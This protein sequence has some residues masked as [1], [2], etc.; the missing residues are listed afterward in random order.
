M[1]IAAI[2]A[3]QPRP[4]QIVSNATKAAV[5]NF[6]KSL[7]IRYA[8]DNVRVNCV[9]PGLILTPRRKRLIAKLAQ[10]RGVTQ[11]I[12]LQE[13]A[14]DVPFGRLGLPEEVAAAVLFLLS[15][16]AGF[17]TGTSIDVDGGEARYI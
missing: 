16:Q 12:I 3:R 15:D 8:K 13:Q 1:N 14:A 5:L 17:I 6:S 2:S 10:D 4:R 9:N 11:E 7:A